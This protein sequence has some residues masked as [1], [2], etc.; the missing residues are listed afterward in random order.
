MIVVAP[1]TVSVTVAP[2]VPPLSLDEAKA[3]CRV[4]I[5]AWDV[6]IASYV[7]AARDWFEETGDRSLLSQTLEIRWDQF[8]GQGDDSR[9]EWNGPE[10][11]RYAIF[12]PRPPLQSVTSLKYVA[13]DGSVTTLTEGTDFVVDKQSKNARARIVP[14][15]GTSWPCARMEPG[16]VRLVGVFGFGSTAATVP[17]RIRQLMRLLTAHGF[18]ERNPV[19]T[20]TIVSDLP[21]AIQTLFW[22]ARSLVAA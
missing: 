1:Y 6:E 7:D 22:S 4:D 12:V 14:A 10:V 3:A 5:A 16:A 9:C 11:N 17:E 8:P 15:F 18:A 2:T 20:G 13:G 19:I 21:H